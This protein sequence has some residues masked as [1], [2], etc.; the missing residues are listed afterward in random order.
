MFRATPATGGS[1][2]SSSSSAEVTIQWQSALPVRLA[3]AKDA[4]EDAS[5]V[6]SQPS[7]EYVIAVIGL[8]AVDVDGRT[9]GLD[10][11]ETERFEKR[12]KTATAL[13]RSGHEPLV[14]LSIE[15]DQNKDGQMLFHFAKTDPI[16]LRDK[17]VEFR[18]ASAGTKVRKKFVLKEME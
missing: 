5:G 15:L 13:L 10:Q 4:G 16:T 8:P 9:G 6:A 17:T 2:G 12:L 11:Q 14:P 7:K 1:S 18:I 3:A